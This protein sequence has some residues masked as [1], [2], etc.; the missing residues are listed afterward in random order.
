V[1]LRRLS[2]V[3][4]KIPHGQGWILRGQLRR[5]TFSD[6]RVAIQDEY[7]RAL[8]VKPFGNRAPNALSSAADQGDAPG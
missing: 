1:N 8:L 6:P 4:R 2:Q 5:G 3:S 7:A